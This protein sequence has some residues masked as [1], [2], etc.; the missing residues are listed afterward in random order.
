MVRL[1]ICTPTQK[2]Y[3][4]RAKKKMAQAKAEGALAEKQNLLNTM[5]VPLI[6]VDPNT[7]EVVFCNQAAGNLGVTTGSRVADMVAPDPRARAHYERMQVAKLEPRRAY[8]LPIMHRLEPLGVI[9]ANRRPLLG[10]IAGVI[11]RARSR[12]QLKIMLH[13]KLHQLR[14]AAV[15]TG[16]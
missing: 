2:E 6:V 11:D 10:R 12:T 14:I 4:K 13:P 15:P 5:Q 9:E 7:D 16:G 3:R 1:I 8:G